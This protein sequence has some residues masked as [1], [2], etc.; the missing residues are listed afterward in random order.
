MILFFDEVL[1]AF[2]VA[3]GGAQEYFGITPDLCVLGKAFGAGLPISAISGKREIMS[4]MRPVGDSEHSGTYLAHLT[5]VLGALAALEE[6][7]G[8]GFYQRMN[9]MSDR[10][11]NAFQQLI[12]RSSLPVRLQF[13][14]PRFGLHFGLDHALK[15]YRDTVARNTDMEKAF[16]RACI[17]RGV[18]FHLALH[19]GFSAAHTD[20]DLDRVLD[21]IEHALNDVK[22]LC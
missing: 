12:D 8:A 13:A 15:R 9:E 16:I 4:H 17:D 10:F 20:H 7:S 22:V 2:R 14:G 21:A 5:T 1:T 3:L 11:Y 18:Y 6:Y 19:H